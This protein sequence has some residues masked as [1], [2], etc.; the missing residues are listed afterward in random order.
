MSYKVDIIKSD[1]TITEVEEF[2]TDV[3][4]IALNHFRKSMS[5]IGKI[6]SGLKVTRVKMYIKES[7]TN[8]PG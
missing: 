2:V 6:I 1:G 5:L 7:D 3:Y 4:R 8:V